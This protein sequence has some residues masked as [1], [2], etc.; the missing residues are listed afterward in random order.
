[1]SPLPTRP[2][3][4]MPTRPSSDRVVDLRALASEPTAP[5]SKL[6]P[7]SDSDG[8]VLRMRA[9]MSK[10]T[11]K[12]LLM[13]VLVLTLVLIAVAAFAWVLRRP[14]FT[15]SRV[16][17][18]FEGPRE[19]TSG[20]M[21]AV[22]VRIR[23]GEAAVLEQVV[24]ELAYPAEFSAIEA[25]PSADGANGE[26]GASWQLDTLQ[27]GQ[28]VTIRLR[29]RVSGTPGSGV[30]VN[31]AVH[32]VP[33][34]TSTIYTS[35]AS[36][37]IALASARLS[38]ATSAPSSV[39][40]GGEF[41][42]RMRVA[43]QESFPLT[44]VVVRAD[45]PPGFQRKKAT[46]EPVGDALSWTIKTLA[47]GAA[48]SFE[49]AGT[50]NGN[51]GDSATFAASAGFLDPSGQFAVQERRQ[52]S[53][54]IVEMGARLELTMNG[55]KPVALKP[56]T[57]ARFELLYENTGSQ[58]IHHV[59][60]AIPFSGAVAA[61]D[62]SAISVERGEVVNN[63][64]VRFTADTLPDLARIDPGKGG[65]LSFSLRTADP[66]N[67]KKGERN[68]EVQLIPS[69]S[70]RTDPTAGEAVEVKGSA[71][72]FR[73]GTAAVMDVA[74]LYHDAKGKTIG[75]G[76]VPPVM[77]QKTS[78]VI[79]TFLSNTTN[80]V[81]GVTVTYKFPLPIKV[82]ALGDP[83]AGE[84]KRNS[85][86]TVTWELGRLPEEAGTALPPLEASFTVEVFPGVSDLGKT[87]VLLTNATFSGKDA[88][89]DLDVSLLGGPL[90]TSLPGDAR[91]KG[92]GVVV[93]PKE[94]N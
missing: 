92:K 48:E 72:A 10:R 88:F 4:T 11:K 70:G 55:G 47:P 82:T 43:N 53:V 6:S 38:V 49:L 66:V 63:N 83:S 41:I 14:A 21:A 28:E 75:A 76:P 90:D 60:I 33:Q 24:L 16:A 42:Y 1:M 26:Q 57:S 9:P 85:N 37:T 34:G 64:Q 74:A 46:P 30:G 19:V 32:Y 94:T 15:G 67:A 5:T 89:A 52:D 12:I 35:D 73:I 44:Q 51:V 69:L 58:P 91:A 77:G 2:S 80:A 84:L 79:R 18:A 31:G 23:N 8:P 87:L 59:T 36:L 54:P 39:T 45:V 40:N 13:S 78:Y 81:E 86:G 3:S 56:G 65:K 62:A 17:L 71:L 7:P 93:A 29:A 27:P 25:E 68:L 50:L 22:D 61:L 20:G